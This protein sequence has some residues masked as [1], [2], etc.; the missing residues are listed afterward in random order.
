MVKWFEMSEEERVKDIYSKHSIKSFWDWWSGGQDK[1]MEIRIKDIEK[2]KKVSKDYDLPWSASGVYVNNADDLKRVIGRLRNDT[3]M[4]FS[5]NP[6]KR[7]YTAYS[8]KKVF[9]GSDNHVE[10]IK[11]LF[12]DIDR[13]IKEKPATN[14]ELGKC[15]ALADKILERL[16]EYGWNK[17]YIKICSGHG[18]QV[19]AKLDERIFIPECEFIWKNRV[20]KFN[21]EFEYIKK[22]LSRGI[23]K[24]IAQFAER[25]KKE[26]GCD[27]DVSG[28][29]IGKVGALPYTK[30][31]KYG[32]ERWRGIV[33]MHDDGPNKDFTEY[34][35]S[36]KIVDERKY[37]V[38]VKSRIDNS[39]LIKPGK[40]MENP[41]ARLLLENDFPRGNINNTLWLSMKIL[42][43]D[44]MI[45]LSSKE[46]L[47]F[48][49]LI[50]QKHNRTFTTN[51]PG[52]MCTF[53]PNTVNNYCL[54][55]M[56]YPIYP[57]WPTRILNKDYAIGD[58]T[59][60]MA[61]GWK[62]C[63]ELTADTYLR[64]FDIVEKKLVPVLARRD[65]NRG[66]RNI[67]K[68]FIN[69][70]I[71]KYGEERTKFFIKKEIFQKYFQRSQ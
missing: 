26:L 70:F 14:E 54:D 42:L 55:E 38:F 18:C 51:I 11:F 57:L 48:H 8:N 32:I 67:F 19:L 43:R 39:Y 53:N 4:W 29:F 7:N 28:F 69:G 65:V 62:E 6:K 33:E 45:D 24:E 16:A 12:I 5:V 52:E 49:S 2:I 30:N 50:K 59:V 66:N 46:F 60:D 68:S 15:D 1:F 31:L 22:I 40:F 20:Y 64:N 61:D 37:T 41:L 63:I 71:K 27:V 25:F 44:S 3:V 21:E 10:S 56:I 9:S 36:K 35:I 17:N 34:I 58:I 13:V 47:E 23:G